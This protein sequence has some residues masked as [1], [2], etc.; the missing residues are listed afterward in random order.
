MQVSDQSTIILEILMKGKEGM[1]N[2]QEETIVLIEKLKK[3][4]GQKDMIN[5]GS[6]G[7]T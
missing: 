7:I 3:F 2:K 1:L 6:L 4:N 5:K